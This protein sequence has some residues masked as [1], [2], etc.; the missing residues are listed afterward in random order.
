MQ[1]IARGCSYRFDAILGTV[2]SEQSLN[3]LRGKQERI[4]AMVQDAITNSR[5]D[6][7]AADGV[8]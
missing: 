6:T 3:V 1:M 5:G 2:S 7:V 8:I 4:V